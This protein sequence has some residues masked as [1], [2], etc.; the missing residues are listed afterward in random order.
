MGGLERPVL[1]KRYAGCRLYGPRIGAYLTRD[2][3]ITMAKNGEKF[4]VIDADSGADV[5]SS[6]HPIIVEH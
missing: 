2:D 1:V 5:T 6:Y 4:V 3:L